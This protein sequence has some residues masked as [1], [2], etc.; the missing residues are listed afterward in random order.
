IYAALVSLFE[1]NEPL[2]YITLANILRERKQLE[3]IG[4]PAYIAGLTDIVPLSANVASYA[5]IVREKAILRRLI[6]A[7]EQVAALGFGGGEDPDAAV[8][9]AEQLI[10]GLAAG[11]TAGRQPAAMT[12]AGILD[13]LSKRSRNRGLTGVP[14]GFCDLDGLLAGGLQES[15]LII[16][17]ARPA[18][19]KTAL[20]LNMALHAAQQGNVPVGVF[21]LEMSGEQLQDRLL[22]AVSGV[23]LHRLRSGYIGDTDWSAVNRAAGMVAG[24]PILVDDEAALTVSKLRARARRLRSEHNIG[25]VVVDYLQLMRGATKS[26]RRDLE[27]GEISRG[28]KAMA[29]ELAVPVLALSQL[30]RNLENRDN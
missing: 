13:R 1:K 23:G 19:G 6:D 27:I 30:S 25:L 9:A 18:M 22:S 21:S 11:R 26:E 24:L 28:L 17:A 3:E 15:D 12:A 29:K 4:G 8:A 7:G 14:T 5:G 2:D 16:L 10:F 20:A